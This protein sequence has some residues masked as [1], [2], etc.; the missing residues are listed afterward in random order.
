MSQ[1]VYRISS[2]VCR[3]V[4]GVPVGTNLALVR[5]LWMVISGRLVASRGAV[6][7]PGDGE[8]DRDHQSV[9]TT[10]TRSDATTPAPRHDRFPGPA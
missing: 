4:E 3:L 10:R 5:L 1:I 9:P 6:D 7:T 2:I 8:S